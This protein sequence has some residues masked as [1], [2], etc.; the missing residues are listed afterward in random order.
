MGP[1][2]QPRVTQ[3]SIP[4]TA[5]S[6]RQQTAHQ[7][8][9]CARPRQ[10]AGAPGLEGIQRQVLQVLQVLQVASDETADDDLRLE[11]RSNFS[12]APSDKYAIVAVQSLQW[13]PGQRC[14]RQWVA[15]ANLN[16]R[17]AVRLRTPGWRWVQSHCRHRARHRRCDSGKS[18]WPCRPPGCVARPRSSRQSPG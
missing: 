8:T 6:G 4:T 5:C 18:A 14:R 1:R 7:P 17:P 12:N 11:E 2:Q 16:A 15:P 10:C 3:A 13:L 9:I